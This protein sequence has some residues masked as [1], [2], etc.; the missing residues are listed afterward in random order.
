[1]PA[2][3][4]HRH[5]RVTTA[6]ALAAALT[7]LAACTGGTPA[8]APEGAATPTV[9]PGPQPDD[10]VATAAIPSNGFDVEV[11]VYPLVRH[12]EYVVLTVD[13]TAVAPAVPEDDAVT[14]FGF[15]GAAFTAE[16][17]S[18][19]V[20]L[21]LLDLERDVVHHVARDDRGRPVVS[22]NEWDVIRTSDG[23][24]LQTAYAAPPPEVTS[25]SVLLPGAPLLA[26]VPVI[27]GDLPSPVRPEVLEKERAT[28]TAV[29]EPDGLEWDTIVGAPTFPLESASVELDGAVQTVESVE[30]V[31]VTLGSDVLFEFDQATLTPAASEAITLVAQ[32]IAEREPGTVAVVGHTDDQGDDA[33]NQ[34][35][36][37]RR[38]Q[39]VADTLAGSIGTSYPLQV[40]G[41]GEAEP[42]VANDTEDNRARNR[43]VTVTLASTVVTRTDLTATGELPPFGE[44][45]VAGAAGAGLRLGTDRSRWDLDATARHVHGHL[46]VDLEVAAPDDQGESVFGALSNVL[47]SH[48]G[49]DTVVP[50]QNSGRVTVLDGALRLYPLD[51]RTADRENFPGGEWWTVADLQGTFTMA[52]GQRRTFSFVYPRLETTEVTIQA[53]DGTFN[54]AD[55]RMTGVPVLSDEAG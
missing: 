44:E 36:S 39:T 47:S 49:D 27:E 14:L 28:S 42:F 45:G 10:V 1:M 33:Y 21:R 18:G 52:G 20:N 24:R 35:L 51:Y 17:M 54:S 5:V 15:G 38:A 9:A 25:L 30:K 40:E 6:A 22:D 12:E 2:P 32:R 4:R 29:P 53:G 43:R 26:E 16:I 46:V 11:E 48:R 55:F 3:R 8:P 41:R 13:F 7:V 50:M 19:P 37:Q 31:E 23:T 34:D